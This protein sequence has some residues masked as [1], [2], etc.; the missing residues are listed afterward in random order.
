MLKG[1]L[2]G[3]SKEELQRLWGCNEKIAELNY[4][5]LRGMDLEKGVTPAVLA[6]EGIQYQYMA[7]RVFEA[8][9]WE[10]VEEYVRILSGFYGILRPLDGVVPYRLEMQAKGNPEGKGNLYDFWK[11][12]IYGKLREETDCIVNLA[13]K[14]YSRCVEDWLTAVKRGGRRWCRRGRRRRWREGKWYGSRRSRI[15]GTGGS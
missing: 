5:R 1:W 8:G 12:A 11:D 6:Y 10:Y 7:P 9:E 3:Q 13:S 4:E 15:S 14:E 2:Q